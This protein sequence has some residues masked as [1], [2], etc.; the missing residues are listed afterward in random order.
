MAEVRS[1]VRQVSALAPDFSS[2]PGTKPPECYNGSGFLRQLSDLRTLTEE[3]VKP[4]IAR[5][6]LLIRPSV[7]PSALQKVSPRP[8]WTP[9]NLHARVIS[10]WH[11]MVR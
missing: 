6:P 11:R 1:V 3:A 4:A 8:V 9:L 5:S 10:S 7:V 2:L